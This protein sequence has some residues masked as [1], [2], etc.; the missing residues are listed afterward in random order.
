[1]IARY[2]RLSFIWGIPGIVLQFVGLAIVIA[3]Q[4][5][6]G[7][8]VSSEPF[9]DSVAHAI[10][11]LGFVA[12]L[13]GFAYYAKAKGRSA[14]W[15]LFAFLSLIGLIV[16]GCLKDRGKCEEAETADEETSELSSP[17]PAVN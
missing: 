15:C 4:P 1:M 9:R 8:M 14:W 2:N 6:K 16:L 3:V 12:L 17:P 10:W 7:R 13:A 11:C 5:P